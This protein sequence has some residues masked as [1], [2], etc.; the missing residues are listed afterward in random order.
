[1]DGNVNKH[2][3]RTSSFETSHERRE[4]SCDSEKVTVWRALSI[5]RV[6]GPYNFDEPIVS[7]N[8]YLHLLNNY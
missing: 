5:D 8:G 2:N 4:L 1:M 3:A 6:I 7:G